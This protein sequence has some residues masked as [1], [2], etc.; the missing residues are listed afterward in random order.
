MVYYT[1]GGKNTKH[2]NF[3]G[4]RVIIEIQKR[5]YNFFIY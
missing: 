5:L 2:V 3:T 4:G 1:G